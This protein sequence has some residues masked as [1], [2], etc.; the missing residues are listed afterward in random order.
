MSDLTVRPNTEKYA[1]GRTKEG[2][3]FIDNGDD[4]AEKLRGLHIQEVYGLVARTLGINHKDLIKKYEHLN[5]GMQRM[6]LG[7][8]MRGHLKKNA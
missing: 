5:V 7:N 8:L 2:F 1:K 6:A 4:V 3:R